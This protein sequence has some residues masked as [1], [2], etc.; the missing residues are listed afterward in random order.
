MATTTKAAAAP[1][2]GPRSMRNY[3]RFGYNHRHRIGSS[4]AQ[5]AA[6]DNKSGDYDDYED[7]Y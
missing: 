5:R 4:R 2:T 1:S 6:D 7:M 3:S